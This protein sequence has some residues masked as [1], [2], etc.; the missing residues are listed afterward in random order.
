MSGSDLEGG[1]GEGGRVEGLLAKPC[2]CGRARAWRESALPQRGGL[3]L[4]LS[5]SLPPPK[6]TLNQA[7]P[8]SST[9][10][11][12]TSLFT[13]LYSSSKYSIDIVLSLVGMQQEFTVPGFSPRIR[14]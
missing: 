5:L 11:L 13:M 8:H 7:Q 2:V 1:G 6:H 14:Y 9:I 4:S 12:G 10:I 3:A